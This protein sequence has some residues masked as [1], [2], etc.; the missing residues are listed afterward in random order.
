MSVSRTLLVETLERGLVIA[1]REWSAWLAAIKARSDRCDG[2]DVSS[3]RS[4]SAGIEWLVTI[5]R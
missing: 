1:G 5:I 4:P 3:V 2:E